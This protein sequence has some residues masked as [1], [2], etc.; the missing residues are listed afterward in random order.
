VW[1]TEVARVFLIAQRLK[2]VAA[3]LVRLAEEV[4]QLTRT[5][6]PPRHEPVETPLG[7][8]NRKYLTVGDAARFVG[9]AEQTLNS[10][11]VS[12]HGPAYHK[13]GR[14]VVYDVEELERWIQ[15]RRLRHTSDEGV[16]ATRRS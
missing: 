14:R 7:T 11:R 3:E 4:E 12:G 1:D 5:L 6:E 10:W 8:P 9:L 16:R 2:A 15:N 13:L